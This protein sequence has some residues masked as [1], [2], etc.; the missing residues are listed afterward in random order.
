MI[1]LIF[2][3]IKETRFWLLPDKPKNE[4][5][6]NII[7]AFT[8]LNGKNLQTDTVNDSEWFA[9]AFLLHS[10]THALL[11]E[12]KAD[13]QDLIRQNI[14]RVLCVRGNEFSKKLKFLKSFS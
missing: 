13:L 6:V 1:L 12:H 9:A 10:L 14:T 8:D 2:I 3:G 11:E 5:V 7:E 4:T